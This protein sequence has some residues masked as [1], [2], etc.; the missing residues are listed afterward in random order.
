MTS[1]TLNEQVKESFS[2]AL[3]YERSMETA[4]KY[5]NNSNPVERILK[6]MDPQDE[7][8]RKETQ[9]R[10]KMMMQTWLQTYDDV[11][12]AGRTLPVDIIGKAADMAKASRKKVSQ[13]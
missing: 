9:E 7:T 4:L 13:E 1:E 8:L 6:A 11:L 2:E 10:V 3:F 5:M 12:T